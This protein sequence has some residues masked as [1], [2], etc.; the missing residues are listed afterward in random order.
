MCAFSPIRLASLRIAGWIELTF[1]RSEW[2]MARA[3]ERTAWMQGIVAFHLPLQLNKNE[4]V[5]VLLGD[6]VPALAAE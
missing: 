2:W 4:P 3:S 5:L 6:R 1:L